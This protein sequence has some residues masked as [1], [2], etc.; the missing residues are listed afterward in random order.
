MCPSL[1]DAVS[2][3]L[4]EHALSFDFHEDDDN[5]CE[6]E[7]DTNIMGQFTCHN[8]GFPTR[9]W[10]SKMVAITIRM[11]SGAE[12]NARVYHQLCKACHKLS[13]LKLD[14]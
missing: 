12:Y 7:Y 9:G 8:G 2:G 13:K 14:E 1:H 4:K 5:A 10:S 6:K 11:Y 3:L